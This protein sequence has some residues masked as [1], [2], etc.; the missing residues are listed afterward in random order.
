MNLFFLFVWVR[1][2]LCSSVCHGTHF[3][4]QFGL[5][6]TKIHLPLPSKYR[7]CMNA[8]SFPV[9][10]PQSIVRNM[11]WSGVIGLNFF[12]YWGLGSM[13]HCRLENMVV[14]LCGWLKTM[15]RSWYLCHR[16]HHA[17][18]SQLGKWAK[19]R[20]WSVGPTECGSPWLFVKLPNW[21]EANSS[22]GPPVNVPS[23]R[24]AQK[25]IMYMYVFALTMTSRITGS[26]SVFLL[27]THVDVKTTL[28]L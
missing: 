26:K 12:F 16:E 23:I 6:F 22:W 7:D 17:P 15:T 27:P 14:S 3:V 18:Y 8:P 20:I 19:C 13:V 21:T 24:L 25:L 10:S 2:S 1:T 11:A 28:Y 4:D 9:G 5:E